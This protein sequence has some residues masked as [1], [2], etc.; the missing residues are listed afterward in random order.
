MIYPRLAF[1]ASPAIHSIFMRPIYRRTD[2]RYI[3]RLQTDTRARYSGTP[4]IGVVDGVRTIIFV[5][6]PLHLL[7]NTVE[8]NPAGLAAFFETALIREFNPLQKVN[9]RRF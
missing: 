3:Y 6:L 1:N 7:N 4:T 2:A 8:G 9:R 5:G